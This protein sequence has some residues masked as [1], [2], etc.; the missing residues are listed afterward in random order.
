MCGIFGY[1]GKN[2]KNFNRDKFDKLGIYNVDRGKSSCGVS[3][4]G[5]IYIGL[6]KNKL[7]YDF[8]TENVINPVT[9]PVVIGHTRQSSVGAVNEYNAH[10]FGFGTNNNNS[11]F[12]FIGCHNGTLHNHT[13][14]AKKYNI[15]LTAPYEFKTVQNNTVESVRTKIDSEILLE[16][17]YKTKNFKVLSEYI[18]GAALFWTDTDNP[19]VAYLWK[20]ASRTSS[21]DKITENNVE[22]PLFVYCE[23]DNSM[24]VSSLEGALK[25]ISDD[26]E[27]I[28]S[29]A[30]NVVYVITD[31]DFVNAKKIKISRKNAYQKEAYTY[32]NTKYANPYAGY[33]QGYGYDWEY[34]AC[35]IP[36]VK[37]EVISLPSTTVDSKIVPSNIYNETTIKSVSEYNDGIYFNK[38]RFYRN[39]M[40]ITGIY[41]WIP[42]YGY[43]YLSDN[44]KEATEEYYFNAGKAFNDGIFTEPLGTNQF[45]P[46]K[47]NNIK[48]ATLFYFVEGVNLRTSI[49][50]NITYSKFLNKDS[51][52]LSFKQLSCLSTHPIIDLNR[53][54]SPSNLQN[55]LF[56]DKLFNGQICP[57][58][59]DKK[60]TIAAGNLVSA[61][62][63]T[64]GV[65]TLIKNNKVEDAWS[66]SDRS[67]S[68]DLDDAYNDYDEA[69][70]ELIAAEA[71]ENEVIINILNEDL[72]DPIC[73]FQRLI[74]KLNKYKSN[75]LADDV[76]SFLETSM[77]TINNFLKI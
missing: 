33:G 30:E 44:V 11:G 53:T 61:S 3:Y 50:Y 51:K 10:P 73:D 43:Y 71:E 21:I 17:L 39:T 47:L 77:S 5:E 37:K 64:Y 26:P 45:I 7:Y 67:F 68:N 34:D 35:D 48:H 18:G 23:N 12:K 4:D 54:E 60:Y 1:L 55:I 32:S 57:L 62:V 74:N 20:G 65:P 72:V 63:N 24:Y 29:V 22:R 19:N 16:I 49:D 46:F 75:E 41:T 9:Y 15:D 14:L 31:G 27:K 28:Y 69:F 58:G 40:L 66:A 6:D 2:P 13:A 42:N 52:Y 70:A 38:L 76:V 8:I 59:S 56:D 36:P 25:S